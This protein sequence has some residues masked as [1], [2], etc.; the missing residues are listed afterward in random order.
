MVP[1]MLAVPAFVPVPGLK[2]RPAGRPEEENQ[3][4]D[5]LDGGVDAVALSVRLTGFPGTTVAADAEV[6][7]GPL[8]EVVAVCSVT[9]SI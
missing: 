4:P 5:V 3:A 8:F 7:I 2:V 1:V 9:E 6:M